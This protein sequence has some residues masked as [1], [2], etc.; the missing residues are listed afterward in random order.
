M[1]IKENAVSERSHEQLEPDESS[2]GEAVEEA[3]S[4]GSLSVEDDPEGTKSPADLA[5]TASAD[6]ATV[7]YQ[8]SASEA[9]KI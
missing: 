2:H 1:W 3:E 9:D 6:D 5:G 4:H 7:G 8:P